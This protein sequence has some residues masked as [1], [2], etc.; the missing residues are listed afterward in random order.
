LELDPNDSLKGFFKT[1]TCRILI[2]WGVTRPT[3]GYLPKKLPSIF[4]TK[5]KTLVMGILIEIYPF[6]P[7]IVG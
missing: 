6:K 4:L 2:I 1:A 3:L 7:S 5:A